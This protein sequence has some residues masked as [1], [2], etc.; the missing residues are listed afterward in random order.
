MDGRNRMQNTW[1]M[2]DQ[3]SVLDADMV[4][5]IDGDLHEDEFILAADDLMD[6]MHAVAVDVVMLIERGYHPIFIVSFLNTLASRLI[7]SMSLMME[8]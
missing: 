7:M 8:L 5:G 6:V 4:A 3:D 1:R 2:V